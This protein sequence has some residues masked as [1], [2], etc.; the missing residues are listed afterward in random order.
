MNELPL[1]DVPTKHRRLGRSVYVLPSLFT[2]ANIFCG[3]YAI[4]ATMNGLYPQAACAIG[5]AIILDSMDGFIARDLD[6]NSI[7]W[8][9]LFL[10]A[11]LPLCLLLSGDYPL[12]ISA[13]PGLQPLLLLFAEQCASP[14]LIFKQAT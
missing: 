8:Q 2:V 9:M 5:I 6:C 7:P 12:W 1:Q 10:S 13:W 4:L 14:D 3:Y 11:L